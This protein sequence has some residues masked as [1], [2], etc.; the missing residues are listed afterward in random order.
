M[1]FFSNHHL[2]LLCLLA[3]PVIGQNSDP[4]VPSNATLGAVTDVVDAGHILHF[5]GVVDAYGH[6]SV[7]DPD[8]SSQF[9]MSISIAPALATSQH[10]ATYDIENATAIQLTLNS[11]VMGNDVPTGFLERFIHSEIYKAFPDIGGVVHSHTP[12]VLP[13][14]GANVPL[15]A[16]MTTGG[17]IGTNGTPVFDAGTLDA[18]LLPDS[19]LHDLLVRNPVIGAALAQTFSN[20][21]QLVLMKGHGMAVR[22]VSLRDA[23][24]RA[25]YARQ[26]AIVQFQSV[27]LGGGI[28]GD[29]GLSPREAEDAANTTES[30]SLLG[31]AWQLWTAQVDQDGL[32]VNDLRN[33]TMAASAGF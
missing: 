13:F 15:R 31:R 33:G 25:F 4:L 23:V 26:N 30:A 19:Q 2:I 29:I 16:Q 7:R 28:S 32:Y 12:E 17:S 14:A 21:S 24:F 9:I 3:S 8:N 27:M 22:G 18:S 5:L 10:I 20:D 6:V 11:S 1:R